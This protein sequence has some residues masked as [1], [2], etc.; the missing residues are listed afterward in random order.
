M[1]YKI[2]C[3]TFIQWHVTPSTVWYHNYSVFWY[4]STQVAGIPMADITVSNSL[5]NC[6]S[7]ILKYVNMEVEWIE[8]WE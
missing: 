6:K 1:K 5:V 8:Y 4:S 7:K 2:I 3:I